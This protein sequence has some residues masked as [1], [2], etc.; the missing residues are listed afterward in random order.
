MIDAPAA[1]AWARLTTAF[2]AKRT[3]AVAVQSN[4]DTALYRTAAKGHAMLR[5]I[6][7]QEILAR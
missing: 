4:P 1:R 5:T 7:S 2:H 3:T 6:T